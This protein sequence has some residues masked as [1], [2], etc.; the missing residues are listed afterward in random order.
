MTRRLRATSDRHVAL[1]LLALGMILVLVFGLTAAIRSPRAVGS[2]PLM[3]TSISESPFKGSGTRPRVTLTVVLAEAAELTVRVVDFDGKSVRMLVDHRPRDP[4]TYPVAWDGRNDSGRSM[5]DGPYRMRATAKGPSGTVA[6]EH[7]VTKAPGV[8]YPLLPGAIVVAINPGHGGSDSGASRAGT[9]EKTINLDISNRV[10]RM[11]EAAGIRVVMTRS[12]DVDVNRPAIDRNGNGK[13]DHTD[14]LVARNDIGNLARADLMLNIHNNATVCHC[15]AGTET[16]IHLKRPWTA[17]SRRLARAVQAAQVRRLKA[18]ESSTWKVIDRGLGSG[19][20]M[21]LRPV[22]SR[23]RRPSLMPAILG[24]SLYL[25]P[26]QERA[27]LNDPQ[28]P[29]GARRGVLR[30]CH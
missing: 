8:P 1:V 28:G 3:G 4:G 7:W 11:L 19:E 9:R 30:W 13:V 29:H 22:S 24:E 21:S 18:F 16:F 27:R 10:R 20:Y 2:S 6:V 12:T 14:E 15:G 5:P 26:V 23:S 17:E 25:D